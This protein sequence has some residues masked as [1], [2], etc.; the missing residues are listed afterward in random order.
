VKGQ[1]QVFWSVAWWSLGFTLFV[2]LWLIGGKRSQWGL[3]FMLGSLVVLGDIMLTVKGIEIT[4]GP[5]SERVKRWV[6]AGM[7]LKYL[8]LIAVLY[9]LARV[10]MRTGWSF[11]WLV[12]GIAVFPLMT[13]LKAA[14]LV[15]MDLQ[16]KGKKD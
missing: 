15:L 1:G 12:G 16:K 10:G 9:E 4:L 14:G 2:G 3:P 13:T 7:V 5:A 6:R 8:V 11:L